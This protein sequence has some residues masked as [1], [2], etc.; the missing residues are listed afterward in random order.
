[1]EWDRRGQVPHTVEVLPYPCVNLVLARGVVRVHGVGRRRFAYVLEGRDSV[2]G[3]KFRPGGFHPFLGSDVSA[4]TDR[5]VPIEGVFGEAGAAFA[6][7]LA[8]CDE[9][10]GRI[11][12][13]DGFL[14]GLRPEPDPRA[15]LAAGVVGLA[16]LD[17][18]IDRV[19]DLAARC[20]TT[21]RSLQRLFQAYV[22]VPPKWV[23]QRRRLHHAAARL[24]QGSGGLAALAL[25][26]GYF[27]QAHLTRDFRAL[28]G[29]PP[30]R[31]AVAAG[32]ATA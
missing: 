3:V 6:R 4:L 13:A 14:R 15:E 17:E 30:A 28:V 9:R 29:R 32:S 24:E 7:A 23:L 5:A 26:L 27:D 21:P 12:L 16:M 18:T 19:A 2:F 20:G 25:D 11:A 10:E 1:M 22:G 8:G 31:Y